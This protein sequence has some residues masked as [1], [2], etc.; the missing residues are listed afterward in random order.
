[1]PTV[2]VVVTKEFPAFRG[3]PERFGNGYNFQVGDTDV[4]QEYCGQLAHAVRDM[5]RQFTSGEVRFPYLVAGLLG[6]DALFTEELGQGGPQGQATNGVRHPEA[7]ILAQAKIGPKRYL[8]KYYHAAAGIPQ[9][10]DV[11]TGPNISSWE[12]WLAKLNDGTLPG[13]AISC[14]PNG[15]LVQAT[16]R[17]D[18]FVRTHQLKRRGKRP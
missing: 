14:R 16:W 9:D 5:E 17:A 6:E 18:A 15:A 1:M 13:G 11:V 2:H 10:G 4:T 8:M 7:C 12:G 3:K